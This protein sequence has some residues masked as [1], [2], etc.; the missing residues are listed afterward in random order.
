[1]KNSAYQFTRQYISDAKVYNESSDNIAEHLIL[2]AQ[3]E[4]NGYLFYL[5]E[6]EKEEFENNSERASELIQ[7]IEDWIN[8]NFNYTFEEFQ[9]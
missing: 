3:S 1:M 4:D 7:E 6:D 9:Y 8:E 5:T 2:T